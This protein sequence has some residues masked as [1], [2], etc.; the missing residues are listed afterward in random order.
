MGSPSSL[1][2]EITPQVLLKAY[3]C[4]IFPMAE[5]A[6]DPT[7]YWIEPERRGVLSLEQVHVPRRLARIIKQEKFEVR[8]DSAYEG[9]IE[10][11]ASSR[12]GRR[13]TWINKR[14]RELYAE[15]FEMGY[16]HTVETW[17]NG[18]LVGGLYGVAL[19]GAFFGE[20]MFSYETDASKVAL[21]HLVARLRYGGFS[22]LD[23]Q[24]VTDHLRQFGAQEISR[25]AFHRRLERALQGFGEYGRLPSGVSGA[26][27]LQLVSHTSNVGC[28]TA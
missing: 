22:L 10:G 26:G 17:L 24:F 28:S 9:V 16:C 3:A 6:D 15:L 4:G 14:I 5:S 8:T 7:L 2:I 20:S 25:A 19:G 13:T 18:R 21:I 12:A 11:C 27:I 1:T 23:T